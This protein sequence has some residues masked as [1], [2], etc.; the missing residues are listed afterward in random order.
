MAQ[1]NDPL[2]YDDQKAIAFIRNQVPQDLKS[3]LDDDNDCYI[4][5]DAIYDYYEEKGYLKDDDDTVE[6]DLDDLSDYVFKASKKEKMPLTREE[7]GFFVDA[8]IA[9]CDQLGVFED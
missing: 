5:L 9:Y 8:E 4:L 3:K 2:E 1:Q 7:V 6:I